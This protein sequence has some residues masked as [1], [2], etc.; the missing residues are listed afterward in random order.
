MVPR[1]VERLSVTMMEHLELVVQPKK[2]W[3]RL[4][5]GEEEA[6]LVVDS[7]SQLL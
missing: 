2:S 7:L 1:A 4:A 6:S 3:G 5:W